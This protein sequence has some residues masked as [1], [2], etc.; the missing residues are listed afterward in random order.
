[1]ACLSEKGVKKEKGRSSNG[2]ALAVVLG[3]TIPPGGLDRFA[4]GWTPGG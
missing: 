2:F 4:P 1:M 3:A